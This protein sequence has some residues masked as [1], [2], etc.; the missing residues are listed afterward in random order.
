MDSNFESAENSPSDESPRSTAQYTICI[1]RYSTTDAQFGIRTNFSDF[2]DRPA[3][4]AMYK[5]LAERGTNGGPDLSANGLCS[6][7][8]PCSGMRVERRLQTTAAITR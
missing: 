2:T 8:M 5:T 3:G 1:A 7:L 4:S 6:D